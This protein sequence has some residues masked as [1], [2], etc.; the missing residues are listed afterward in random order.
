[1]SITVKKNPRYDLKRPKFLVDYT[2]KE[3]L[4]VPFNLLVSGFKLILITGNS[5]S[6]KTSLLLSLLTDKTLLKK[7]FNNVIVV[8]P[9][10]SRK[11]LKKDPF[12]DLDPSKQFEDLSEVDKIYEVIKFFST[13]D[14]T[15]LLI[16]DDQQSYLKDYH[17]AQVINHVA[18]NRRHL[19]CTIVI[20][21]QT[22][23]QLALKTRKLV[24]TLVAFKPSV[25]EWK[26]IS[27]ELLEYPEDTKEKIFKVLFP[28]SEDNSHRWTLI[29]VPSQ[30]I[31]KEFDEVVVSD[32]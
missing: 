21:L 13:E 28:R 12:A 15:S 22:Y 9:E 27:E 8:V 7:T 1:M 32:D 5:G 25:K 6:G 11:S 10:T 4:P 17:T 23:N 18:S 16:L 3:G 30:T 29:D 14:E 2:L 24:N 19:H 26:N 31:Y 20:L